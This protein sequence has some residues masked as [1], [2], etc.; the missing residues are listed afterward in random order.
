MRPINV[1]IMTFLTAITSCMPALTAQQ[2]ALFCYGDF[3]PRTVSGLEYVVLEPVLFSKADVDQLKSQNKK[4]LAYISLGEVSVTAGHYPGIK[5]ETLQKNEI[6]DSYVIDINAPKT[7]EALMILIEEHLEDKGF[8]GIFL[9]NMDNYTI[10]GPTPGKKDAML[11]FL[12]DVKLRFR[13][14]VLMQNAGL[15][16]LD[17]TLPYIDVVAVE[18]VATDYNFQN[19]QYRLRNSKDFEDRLTSVKNAHERTGIP[20]VLIE[21]AD[22]K[23]LKKQVEKRLSKVDFTLF[24]G[25]IDLQK[26]PVFH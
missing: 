22:T 25:Q 26:T 21:Y 23:K 19:N 7:R 6:W 16:I 11:S 17:E 13:E 1:L 9:D 8:D 18:S 4:V 20:I 2:S 3:E 12:K 15:L 5:E 14:S 10:Y 24:I